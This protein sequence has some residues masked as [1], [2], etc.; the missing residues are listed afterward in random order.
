[1][2]KIQQMKYKITVRITETR[3]EINVLCLRAILE[4]LDNTGTLRYN[5][6]K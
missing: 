1:M 4:I 5:L 2:L 3:E 6:K